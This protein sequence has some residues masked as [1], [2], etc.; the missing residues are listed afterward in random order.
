MRKGIL[1]LLTIVL[2]GILLA[3]TALADYGYTSVSQIPMAVDFTFSVEFDDEGL[4]HVVTDYP[5]DKTGAAEMN[6]TYNMG[7]SREAVTLNY[8]YPAGTTRIGCFDGSIY[9][10]HGPLDKA[11]EDIR[12]GV[13]TLDDAV[14]INTAHFNNTADWFLTYSLSG[15][16]YVSYSEKTYA[17]AFNGMGAGGVAKSVY[18]DN[19]VI[20]SSRI[21]V[22]AEESD[23]IIYF[24]RYGE[25]TRGSIS[26]YRPES[27][28][29][30]YSLSTGLFNGH[31]EMIPLAIED[32]TFAAICE[33]M[34]V[35]FAICLI[36]LFRCV[37]LPEGRLAHGLRALSQTAFGV[38]IIHTNPLLW[39]W[40]FIPG[41]LGAWASLRAWV[42]IL[43][44]PACAFGVYLLC[45]VPACL[46][47]MLFRRL[48]LRERLEG[49]EGKLFQQLN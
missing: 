28:H 14:V 42:L 3:G 39:Y 24:N 21:L 20:D 8:R 18:Y 23:M 12:N 34:G 7:E 13:V 10:S 1:L 22:R 25:I 27:A 37:R 17:Q 38:Y 19:G 33:E 46:R 26:Q 36:L 6:L 47:L 9:D 45:S 30:T 43:L 31:P 4:P 32:F 49:L 5:F 41:C 35:I 15:K 16:K 40:V 11:Y 2:A 44:I 48:R 29:Y